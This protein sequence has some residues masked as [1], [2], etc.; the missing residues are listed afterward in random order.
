MRE[1]VDCSGVYL[2]DCAPRKA[3]NGAARQFGGLRYFLSGGRMTIFA[4]I[5]SAGRGSRL[6]LGIP[7][8]LIPL[9]VDLTVWDVLKLRLK[10]VADHIIVVLS[11]DGIPLFR[12]AVNSDITDPIISLCVQTKPV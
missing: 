4:V 1:H 11:P 9:R 2:V 6:G 8:V 7:K 5:P 12:K 10:D 3:P